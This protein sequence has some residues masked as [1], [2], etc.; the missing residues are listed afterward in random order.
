ME[1]RL[2]TQS[3]WRLRGLLNDHDGIKERI[4]DLDESVE[5]S[6]E[7]YRHELN[8]LETIPG[9]GRPAAHGSLAEVGPH[10]PR[11]FGSAMR[12]ASWA[13]LCPGSYESA[14]KR[15]SG[16]TR[17]G[18]AT[19]RTSLCESTHAAGRTKGSQFFAYHKA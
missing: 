1:A 15:H 16:H 7:A 6:L 10:P 2:D 14:E 11:T 19:L 18:T 13:G 3:V 17:R 12:L 4:K 9:I 8:L 5:R